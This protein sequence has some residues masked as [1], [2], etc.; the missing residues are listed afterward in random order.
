MSFSLGDERGFADYLSKAGADIPGDLAALD[1]VEP[2]ALA[3]LDD[4]WGLQSGVYPCK[5]KLVLSVPTVP[6]VVTSHRWSSTIAARRK[7]SCTAGA[8]I[9]YTGSMGEFADVLS[10][11]GP[12]EPVSEPAIHSSSLRCAR[13]PGPDV[14]QSPQS[15]ALEG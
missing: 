4:V 2:L 6:C 10:A 15:A 13:H 7:L 14:E 3:D 11:H 1:L 12:G 5:R 8:M 9:L